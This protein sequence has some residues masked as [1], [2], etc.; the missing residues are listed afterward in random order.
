[1]LEKSI[2]AGCATVGFSRR[3]QLHGVTA[4]VPYEAFSGNQLCQR[5]DSVRGSSESLPFPPSHTLN[6]IS[7]V[8]LMRVVYTRRAYRHRSLLLQIESAQFSH[9]NRPGKTTAL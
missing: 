7:T 1:M 9:G 4:T 6:A 2:L 3:A 5:G 8:G